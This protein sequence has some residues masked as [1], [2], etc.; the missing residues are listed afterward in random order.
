M[1]L[2]DRKIRLV[3]RLRR[4]GITDTRVQ[5]AMEQVPREEF[6]EPA[7][8]HQAYEDI[9]LPIKNGQTISQPYVVA[10]MTEALQVEPKS[11][12]LEIGTGSGYQAAVLAQLS[13]RIYT[14]ERH[15][16]LYLDAQAKFERLGLH[17]IVTRHGDGFGGWPTHAPFDR[18]IATAA[19]GQVPEALIDQLAPGG[20]LIAPEGRVGAE[21]HVVRLTKNEDGEVSREVLIP[22][23]FVP[24]VSGVARED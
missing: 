22:V 16:P 9:A 7:L 4:E 5:S 1:S 11:K 19:P 12:I 13:K 15:R 18:I 23:R 21:Q 20:I 8:R 14:I 10:Y 6:V 3:M 2:V 24:M 17:R